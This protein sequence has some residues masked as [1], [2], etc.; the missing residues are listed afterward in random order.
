ME[1]TNW[2]A[3]S[4]NSLEAKSM[5]FSSSIDTNAP[6]AIVAPSGRQYG[7][8]APVFRQS[9]AVLPALLSNYL[10]MSATYS[11]NRAEK[12]LIIGDPDS[13]ESKILYPT[14]EVLQGTLNY[15]FLFLD[16][17][18]NLYTWRTPKEHPEILPQIH[19]DLLG[20]G[21]LTSGSRY[22]FRTL[23]EQVNFMEKA[24]QANLQS[25]MPV[26]ADKFG[27]LSPFIQGT[28]YDQYLRSGGIKATANVLDNIITAHNQNIVYGDRWTKNTIV[29]QDEPIVEIDFDIE[30]IGANAQEFE[31]AQLLYHIL[32]FSNRREELLKFLKGYLHHERA[33]VRHN[34]SVV[35]K[36]LCNYIDYFQDKSVEG[37]SGGIKQE[38]AELIEMLSFKNYIAYASD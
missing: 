4:K 37:I 14:G 12:Q 6:L 16:R 22:Q 19:R 27:I 3:G 1:V 18:N 38:I 24:S 23:Q 5:N 21:F 36:F 9:T 11:N 30:L 2:G 33:L 35:K 13:K 10:S 26:Y 31:M 7:N 32:F 20:T 34:L 8:A 17:N 25:L 15:I 29:K 28:P